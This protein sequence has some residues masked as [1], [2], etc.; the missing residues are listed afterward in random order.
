MGISAS[1]ITQQNGASVWWLYEQVL[2]AQ[3]RVLGA[4]HPD[5]L[6][7]CS[8]LAVAHHALGHLEE[9]I[10][11]DEQVLA[12]RL[13]VLGADHPNTL[14]TR[15]NLAVAHHDGGHWEE[16]IRQC[17]GLLA[18]QLRV[19]GSGTDERLR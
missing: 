12:D 11:L 10:R 2:S 4:D 1:D 5:T 13:R 15:S 9:A 14:S 6:T 16:A 7:T 8:N 17:E 18:D 19:L 3:L